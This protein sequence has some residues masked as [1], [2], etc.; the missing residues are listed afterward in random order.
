[1]SGIIEPRLDRDIAKHALAVVQEEVIAM[2]DRGDIKI[3]IAVIVEIGERGSHADLVWE[4]DAGPVG[5]VF[6]S[7]AS[8]VAPE[9][10]GSELIGEV[11]VQPPNCESSRSMR[12]IPMTPT[13]SLE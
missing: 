11:D 4:P 8:E 7:A 5:D 9:L 1:M 10:I 13:M 12:R 3:R 2:A 6:E